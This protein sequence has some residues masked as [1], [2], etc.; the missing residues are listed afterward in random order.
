MRISEAIKQLQEIQKAEGDLPVYGQ[1]NWQWEINEIEVE[2]DPSN[3]YD[4]K[5][6]PKRVI[7]Y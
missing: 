5:K 1:G 7:V 3:H 2:T 6:E 4:E